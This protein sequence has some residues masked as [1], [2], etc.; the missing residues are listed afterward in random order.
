MK[1]I[2]FTLI[3]ALLPF[4]F[5]AVAQ[6][7]A[8]YVSVTGKVIDSRTKSPV[9]YASVSLSGTG[10]SNITNSEGVFTLKIPESVSSEK[11]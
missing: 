2:I 9:D 11:R 4:G 3:I 10:I 8:G 5:F 7:S 1:R 6:N